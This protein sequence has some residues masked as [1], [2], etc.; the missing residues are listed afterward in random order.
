MEEWTR[1]FRF[2]PSKAPPGLPRVPR[3]ERAIGLGAFEYTEHVL[4]GLAEIAGAWTLRN[5]ARNLILA[6]KDPGRFEAVVDFIVKAWNRRRRSK[7]S[8]SSL[9]RSAANLLGLA[10]D[11]LIWRWRHVALVS[12]RLRD[13]A[14]SS[15]PSQSFRAGYLMIRRPTAAACY[16]LLGRLHD[17]MT[18]QPEGLKDYLSRRDRP[19][20]AIHTV[21][22]VPVGS[23]RK[24]ARVYPVQVRIVPEEAPGPDIPPVQRLDH[25]VEYLEARRDTILVY[26]P[27]RDAKPIPKGSTILNFALAVHT[28]L[29]GRVKEATVAG[30]SGRVGLLHPLRDGDE[31][32]L[33]VEEEVSALPTGWEGAVPQSTVSDIGLAFRR[34]RRPYLKNRGRGVLRS[35]LQRWDWTSLD[36]RLLDVLVA[37]ASRKM[38]EGYARKVSDK[39]KALAADT[40]GWWLRQLALYEARAAGETIRGRLYIDAGA[41]EQLLRACLA[42]VQEDTVI[43]PNLQLPPSL[44][45]KVVRH[46]HC[47]T[48]APDL[49]GPL[50]GT[51][52]GSDLV[53][54]RWGEDAPCQDGVI[55]LAPSPKRRIPAYF[56]IEARNRIGLTRDVLSTFTDLEVDF[57]EVVGRRVGAGL[58]VMR[59][60]ADGI[61]PRLEARII[62]RLR[63]VPGVNDG[64]ILGP[65][66][67][68][69]SPMEGELPPRRTRSRRDAA[70]GRSFPTGAPVQGDSFY[71]RSRSL[72]ELQTQLEVATAVDSHSSERQ[73]FVHGPLKSG[74]TSLV[75]EFLR[76]RREATPGR[77]LTVWREANIRDFWST[78]ELWS[79]YSRRLR[80]D[81][82]KEAE[83]LYR[84]HGDRPP[85]FEG[86]STAEILAE[87]VQHRSR[88]HWI[89]AV[90][91]AVGLLRKN[92]ALDDERP[93]LEDELRDILA[94][95]GG[96]VIW[97]GPYHPLLD[98]GN[99][100]K[101]LR[102]IQGIPVGPWRSLK[103]TASCVRRSQWGAAH[104]IDCHH[105]VA[106]A[107]HRLTGGEPV[108]VNYLCAE[109]E[110]SSR[111]DRYLAGF[112]NAVLTRASKSM[113]ANRVA[114][115]SR[116]GDDG[117]QRPGDW[118][119]LL[120]LARACRATNRD[121]TSM[122]IPD[123]LEAL[124]GAGTPK[125]QAELD[126]DL[127]R[128]QAVGALREIAHPDEPLRYAFVAPILAQYVRSRLTT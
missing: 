120:I 128:L 39:D 61:T 103:T 71:G 87:V 19:Y 1:S 33:H 58:Y 101:H 55:P 6:H 29:V 119:I 54:H 94:V 73:A 41:R 102:A 85:D 32:R 62:E 28:E 18:H 78:G 27:H 95:P 20:R 74:K 75:L 3:A 115:R 109:M 111:D 93:A 89:L 26:T 17:V 91:E 15:W 81:V 31:V 9:S 34:N 72:A 30:V 11:E 66:S 79:S 108:W 65:R 22:L 4:P 46:R 126:S 51:L 83:A 122:T 116:T 25:I 105:D 97:I 125:P 35:Y 36:D 21:V 100:E 57:W 59:V 90:D 2:Q 23:G 37:E 38:P 44:R 80:A 43:A 49:Q 24:D 60:E 63:R 110:S 56:T 8:P 76:R 106:R 47:P 121:D 48:C 86:M 40:A 70:R 16:E 117:S 5:T 50:G 64:G 42:C 113:L 99:V 114:F 127:R 7:L 67:E 98:G 13:T 123:I 124:A 112:S 96:M 88:P 77:V 10:E 84:G 92:L 82:R 68:R 53:L 14:P 118:A 12:E 45:G 107:I 104:R 52:D 69:R